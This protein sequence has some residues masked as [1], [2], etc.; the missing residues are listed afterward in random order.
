[1]CAVEL[2]RLELDVALESPRLPQE[3]A[4]WRS[5]LVRLSSAS[6]AAASALK[7]LAMP[8]DSCERSACG[9][10]GSTA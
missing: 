2:E 3:V 6:A 10:A 4:R 8:E 9:D 1:M 7:P 5:E